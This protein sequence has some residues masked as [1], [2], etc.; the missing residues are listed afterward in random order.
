MQR[1]TLLCAAAVAGAG[2]LAGCADT[3][4]DPGGPGDGSTD[5]PTGSPTDSPTDS[6]TGTDDGSGNSPTDSPTESPTP[7]EEP[8]SGSRRV[9]GRSF[10]VRDN[11]CGQGEDSATVERGDDRVVVDGTISG[12]NSCYTAELKEARYDEGADELTVAVRSYEDRADDEACMECIVDIDY[13]AT[14]EFEGGTPGE[15]TVRHNGERV[16]E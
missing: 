3:D 16:S 13:R 2:A 4:P 15:V 8:G 5:S 6:P 7:T 14:V 11:S 12:R 10:E 1:R 9:T